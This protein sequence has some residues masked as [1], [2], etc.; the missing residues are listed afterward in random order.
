L[1][2][3][4]S[5]HGED[6]LL[7]MVFGD[8]KEGFF[9]EVGC[10]DGRRFSNTLT[11]EERGWKGMCVEAHAGYIESLKKNRPNSII[12][13]CAAGEADEDAIF[14]ANARGSLSTL[15]KSKE[16][17]FQRDYGTYFSGFEE[18][19]VVKA[20]L[21]TLL[22]KYQ[23]D[24]IDIL[25]LDIEGY[26]V[27]AMKGLD[28]SR[29]RPK[30]MVIESDSAEHEAQ[31]DELILP[32]GYIKS[33]KLTVNVYYVCN[34]EMDALLKGKKF[35]INLIH[36]QHPLDSNGDKKITVTVDTNPREPRSIMFTRLRSDLA[37]RTIKN[38]LR[39]IVRR[40]RALKNSVSVPV[41]NARSHGQMAVRNR[42]ADI[43]ARLNM[44]SPVIVDGGANVGDMTA[45]FLN[46]YHSPV[47]HAFEP[48]PELIAKLKVRFAN[49]NNVT[50]HGVAMGA[51]AKT[52]SFNVLNYIGSSSALNP[53]AI[54]KGYHGEKMNVRQV[55]DVQQVRL[56][57]VMPTGCEVD[58]LKLDLQGYELEALKGCG[59]LLERIKI[60]TTEIEF[61]TLYG[62]QPL[63][64]DIDVFLRAHGF[65]MLNLY[66]LYTHP[67]GQLT[68]GDAVYLNSKYF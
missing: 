28:L 15:D 48:I 41:T 33:V 42:F 63:F 57:D 35:E 27:E 30:V 62:G 44:E 29:H 49:Q 7:D 40:L 23:I 37:V 18:Q 34:R 9:V 6:A 39:P 65:R 17:D 1:K 13:H 26:E 11:F 50:I 46:Q 64:G 2:K 4:Y 66:E 20:R 38:M 22:D 45:L 51:E 21:S 54:V 5:Q 52:I 8:Q 47:I 61:V 31:L 14:Y 32:H 24:D 43:K 3:Y 60:I 59:K 56:E 68:A 55:V 19:H 12:C 67:D 25:S 16:N 58:L 10:I 53:S 36:T